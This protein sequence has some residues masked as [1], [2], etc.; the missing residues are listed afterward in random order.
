LPRKFPV[1]NIFLEAPVCQEME[2]SGTI[3]E[4]MKIHLSSENTNRWCDFDQ[5]SFQLLVLVVVLIP[6]EPPPAGHENP[7]N[8]K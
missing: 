2:F 3:S 5:T 1:R 8:L 6:A 7:G 4:P